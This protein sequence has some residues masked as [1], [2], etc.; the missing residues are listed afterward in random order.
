LH[1]SLSKKKIVP[2]GNLPYLHAKG[3]R[4][5]KSKYLIFSPVLH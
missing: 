1:S 2:K 3:Y 4:K 5:Q